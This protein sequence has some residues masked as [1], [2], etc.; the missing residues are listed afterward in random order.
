M[1]I[2][3][4]STKGTIMVHITVSNGGYADS[5]ASEL[6]FLC[7]FYMNPDGDGEL[8]FCIEH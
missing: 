2:P 8:P 5:Q 3:G 7:P 1:F 4:H 6:S